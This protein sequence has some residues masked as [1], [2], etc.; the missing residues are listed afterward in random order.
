MLHWESTKVRVLFAPIRDRRKDQSVGYPQHDTDS[1]ADMNRSE[2]GQQCHSKR[3]S[4]RVSCASSIVTSR[5]LRRQLSSLCVRHFD[6]DGT[7]IVESRQR[8]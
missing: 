2:A 5:P 6:R 8:P 3:R 1:A 7:G 4:S